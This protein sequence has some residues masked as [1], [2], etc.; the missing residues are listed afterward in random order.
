HAA[1]G[2]G[3]GPGVGE[4]SGPEGIGALRRSSGLRI[5]WLTP[6]YEWCTVVSAG[7]ERPPRRQETE[8]HGHDE[9]ALCRDQGRVRGCQRA[10]RLRGRAVEPDGG[11][12]APEQPGRGLQ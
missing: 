6:D 7:E 5:S 10:V 12:A 4:G 9:E 8:R 2:D 3:G 11:G 1:R